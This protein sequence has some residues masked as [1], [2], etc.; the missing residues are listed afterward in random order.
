M[1]GSGRGLLRVIFVGALVALSLVWS[2][3]DLRRVV[4]V[5]LGTFGFSSSNSIVTEVDGGGVAARSGIRV[6]ERISIADT[7]QLARYEL[8][9]GISPYPGGVLEATVTSGS[10]SRSIRLVS[11]PESL[12]ERAFVALRFVLAF[13]TI[14]VATALLLSRPD[15]AAWGFFIY[16]LSAVSLPGATLTMAFGW[17]IRTWSLIPS[18]L[19]YY[20]SGVGGVLFAFAFARVELFGW[21]RGAVVA[22][23][24]AAIASATLDLNSAF[25]GRLGDVSTRLDDFETGLV[26][27]GMLV[28]FTDSFRHDSG[29]ARQRLRWMIAALVI[30]IPANFI[31]STLFPGWLTYGEYASLIA[32]QAIVPLTAAYALFRKRVVDLNFAISRTLVYGTLTA[33]VI[34]VFSILDAILSR[35]FAESRLSLT[36]DITV[37]LLLGFSLNAAHR[38]VDNVID[39]VLFRNRRAAELQVERSAS[40]IVH[41]TDE[42]TVTDT[43]VRLPVHALRLTGSALYRPSGVT[44]ERAAAAGQL[45]TPGAIAANDALVLA[46]RAELQPMR[47]GSVPLSTLRGGQRSAEPVLAIPIAMRGELVG[48][49]VYGAHESG[50]DIDPDEQRALRSLATNAAVAYDHLEVAVLRAR[51]SALEALVSRAPFPEMP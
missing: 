3:A 10:T 40:G 7:S 16:C 47:I 24:I 35:T 25:T 4:G 6:G 15:L 39:S 1:A 22:V 9:R 21:R 50:A 30:S 28:G 2:L 33:F 5:P 49:A 27:L 51:V 41:A 37:A 32:I 17:Q 26:L 19:L 46:L 48:F 13:L 43:L 20:A 44:F 12:S 18:T 14:G 38:R 34:V 45:N 31:A 11:E 29:A 8:A 42:A 23:A 36:I